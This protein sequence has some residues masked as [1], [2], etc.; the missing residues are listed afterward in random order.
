MATDWSVEARPGWFH[1]LIVPQRGGQ[2]SSLALAVAAASALAFVVSISLDWRTATLS[3]GNTGSEADRQVLVLHGGVGDATSLAVAYLLGMVALLGI[4]GAAIG[5]PDVALRMRLPVLGVG[6]GLVG[7]VLAVFTRKAEVQSAIAANFGG[8]LP[9]LEDRLKTAPG[10]G[11]FLGLAATVLAMAAV[12]IAGRAVAVA[13]AVAAREPAG[14]AG[15]DPETE[16][17]P[18]IYAPHSPNGFGLT[19]RG[20]GVYDLT[21]IP[22]DHPNPR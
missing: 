8:F 19:A 5:R 6:V 10:P 16:R 12:W 11:S 14:D 9:D 18:G 2:P 1:R 4:V 3:L 17:A 22:D 7:V 13:D 20:G 21:V 15:A